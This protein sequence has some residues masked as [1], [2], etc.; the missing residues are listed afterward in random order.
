MTMFATL[1]SVSGFIKCFHIV[2]IS[3]L[4]LSDCAHAFLNT[5]SV[6]KLN[7]FRFLCCHDN[8]VRCLAYKLSETFSMALHFTAL[9]C[10]LESFT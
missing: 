6:E 7:T 1:A 4:S 2:H 9:Q 10:Q 5:A 3:C 8:K